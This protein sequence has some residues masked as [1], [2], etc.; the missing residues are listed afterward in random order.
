MK[1]RIFACLLIG[2]LAL[3]LTACE[4]SRGDEESAASLPESSSQE[5]SYSTPEPEVMPAIP[6]EQSQPEEEPGLAPDASEPEASSEPAAPAEPETPGEPELVPTSTAPQALADMLIPTAAQP[7]PPAQTTPAEPV[8]NWKPFALST[9]GEY[10]LYSYHPAFMIYTHMGNARFAKELPKEDPL[11]QAIKA[12]NALKDA[13]EGKLDENAYIESGFMY[14]SND[15]NY[16]KHSYLLQGGMLVIDDKAYQITPEQYENLKK[17]ANSGDVQG[18]S[19]A[20]WL[21]HMDPSRVIKIQCIDTDGQLKQMKA[22]NVPIAAIE[23]RYVD[24]ATGFTYTAG[25]YNFDGLFKTVF[26]FDKE[27][28]ITYTIVASGNQLYVESSDMTFGCQYT[29][30]DKKQISNFIA[31]MQGMING[32]ANPRTM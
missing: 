28:G 16:F 12:I 29:V 30:T 11:R 9:K 3:Q 31:S 8:D 25:S 17:I 10:D 1:Q 13:P 22:E 27:G 21:V 19:S 7:T 6:E 18:T 14:I 4:S 26:T 24:V 5:E 20:Q 15:G 32:P 2:I 23:P